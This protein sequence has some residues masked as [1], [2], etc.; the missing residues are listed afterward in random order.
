MPDRYPHITFPPYQYEHFP[1][2][3]D[4]PN[5]ERKIVH[6]EAEER[7]VLDGA[8]T[9]AEVEGERAEL[10]QEA[11]VRGLKVDKR[12]STERVRAALDAD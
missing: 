10:L 3:I 6:D 9:D 12:W 7:A 4:L 8:R 11:E 5:G 1:L 2:W